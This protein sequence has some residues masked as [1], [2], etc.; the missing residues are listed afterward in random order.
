MFH[1]KHPEPSEDAIVSRETIAIFHY[2][3]VKKQQPMPNQSGA[4]H[5]RGAI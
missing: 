4:Q 1:V 3:Y 2:G 5:T